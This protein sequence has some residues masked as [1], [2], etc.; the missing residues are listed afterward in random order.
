MSKKDTQWPDFVVF[1]SI[2]GRLRWLRRYEYSHVKKK[3]CFWEFYARRRIY[4]IFYF[5]E[6]ANSGLSTLQGACRVPRIRPSCYHL[7]SVPASRTCEVIVKVRPLACCLFRRSCAFL[8]TRFFV[9]LGA[10]PATG[11]PRTRGRQLLRGQLLWTT[12]DASPWNGR[13]D[14]SAADEPTLGR[15]STPP[16]ADSR[17]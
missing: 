7:L 17:G 11:D 6:T 1:S 3:A 5:C 12:P 13:R 4:V 9:S 15:A 8:M 16:R 14:A 2:N 10:L